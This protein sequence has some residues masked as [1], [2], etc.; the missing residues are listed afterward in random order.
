MVTVVTSIVNFM[1]KIM[2]E[3]RETGEKISSQVIL[4]KILRSPGI[5][6]NHTLD[7]AAEN[8]SGLPIDNHKYRRVA[9][10][11]NG[12]RVGQDHQS[13]PP[14]LDHEVESIRRLYAKSGWKKP[15]RPP[16]NYKG[17]TYAKLAEKFDCSKFNI[18]DIVK[19]KRRWQHAVKYKKIRVKE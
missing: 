16:Q 9:V 17:W 3:I 4:D 11:S 2:D 7:F 6:A 1:G 8:D 19:C 14:L 5:T 15:G 13:N 10:G 12:R 18:R